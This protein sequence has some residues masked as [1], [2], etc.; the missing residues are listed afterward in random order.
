VLE[1]I[2][3]ALPPNALT[4]YSAALSQRGAGFATVVLRPAV[5]ELLA[6]LSRRGRPNDLRDPESRRKDAEHQVAVLEDGSIPSEW[7]VDPTAMSVDA[8]YDLCRER[9]FGRKVGD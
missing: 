9:L 8:L 2:L 4:A 5:D 3:Y 1:F 7:L 6:R